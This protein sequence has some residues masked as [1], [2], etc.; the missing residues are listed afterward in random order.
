[1]TIQERIAA[2][3]ASA[4]EASGTPAP[5]VSTVNSNTLKTNAA[6]GC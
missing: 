1:M 2:A 3:A 4:S 6:S 5:Q